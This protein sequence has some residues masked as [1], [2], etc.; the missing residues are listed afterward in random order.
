MNNLAPS[1]PSAPS[2]PPFWRWIA[3]LVLA[4]AVLPLLAIAGYCVML[5]FR[6]FHPPRKQPRGELK[7]RLVYERF[8]IQSTD[9]V[10]LAALLAVPD[11]PRASVVICHE[12]GAHKA[13][14]LKY[15]EMVHDMGCAPLLFDLRNHGESD[16]DAAWGDMS[17]RYTDDLEAV[18]AKVRA[19]ERIGHLPLIVLA[20]SFSTFPAVHCMARRAG[21][22]ADGLI[23]DSGPAFDE[24]DT[25]HRFLGAFSSLLIP[26]WMQGPLLLPIALRL[27]EWL[28]NRFLK[29]DWPP[30][31]E[32]IKAPM[33]LICGSADKV[34]PQ[35]QLR[36]F[37]DHALNA[38]LRVVDSCPHLLAFMLDKEMYRQWVGGFIDRVTVRAG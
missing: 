1:A 11:R 22:T 33:L 19:D 6:I 14:K 5:A 2:A 15:A 29:V 3:D 30:R 20:F 10:S 35:T 23:L 38:E 27:I 12:W 26:R 28:V 32:T 13:S 18:V 9:G 8:K 31:S 25:T 4:V 37:A 7:T 24:R 34:V 36:L 16:S 21:K 17:R